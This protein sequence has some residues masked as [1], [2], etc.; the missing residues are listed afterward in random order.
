MTLSISQNQWVQTQLD[1]YP[2]LGAIPDELFFKIRAVADQ[3]NKLVF[4][5]KNF[6]QNSFTDDLCDLGALFPHVREFSMEGCSINKKP[7]EACSDCVKYFL[8]N[9][10]KW[11]LVPKPP[12][13]EHPHED[14]NNYSGPKYVTHKI[15]QLLAQFPLD[16]IPEH[17][18]SR[19][20]SLAHEVRVLDFS[21]RALSRK[22]LKKIALW[23]PHVDT[24]RLGGCTLG[25]FP[26]KNK[27]TLEKIFGHT[28]TCDFT[29][30]QAIDRLTEQLSQCTIKEQ[31]PQVTQKKQLA[32]HDTSP[33]TGF[34]GF[35]QNTICILLGYLAEPIC[36]DMTSG[37]LTGFCQD[38][39]H[40]LEAY[41]QELA[42]F[43][44]A[45]LK[46]A[47]ERLFPVNVIG[48]SPWQGL[49]DHEATPLDRL[50]TVISQVVDI[51]DLRRLKASST[52][53]D[54]LEHV[55]EAYPQTKMFFSPA[56]KISPEYVNLVK[57]FKKLT[58]L[59]I[60]LCEKD[61]ITALATLPKLISLTARR[62]FEYFSYL[63]APLEQQNTIV[64]TFNSALPGEFMRSKESPLRAV[65][66]R[67]IAQIKNLMQLDLGHVA[68]DVND[69]T[70][71]LLNSQNLPKLEDFALY[72]SRLVTA[73]TLTAFQG[74]KLSKLTLYNCP[75]IDDVAFDI[76]VKQF[77]NLTEL[78]IGSRKLTDAS[79]ALMP[80]IEK[81]KK[82]LIGDHEAITRRGWGHLQKCPSLSHLVITSDTNLSD[83]IF[84]SFA[85]IP[86]L[87]QL[88]FV[89]FYPSLE[90]YKIFL[91]AKPCD[92]C[93]V[94]LKTDKKPAPYAALPLIPSAPPENKITEDKK[95]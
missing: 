12:L 41:K 16:Q 23:F 60:S 14:R 40:F 85:K 54:W 34:Y 89:D 7:I 77:P 74:H 81:L 65:D 46:T 55:V 57:K 76:I 29:P 22:E 45:L 31:A 8:P 52:S 30:P 9:L 6:E 78:R 92:Q 70:L 72:E 63:F 10:K 26:L 71:S 2:T 3:V 15:N 13:L 79:F 91:K 11:S 47:C 88:T 17:L 86:K 18:L 58:F 25:T 93:T 37:D 20:R 95:A 84:L 1:T 75:K 56:V 68:K 64:T 28:L 66:I 80:R 49:S 67:G 24:L 94:I 48:K 62:F 90:M 53:L 51:V 42:P 69:A 83:L 39:E 73:T 4:R 44:S 35:S 5:N 19:V 59:D 43:D 33:I 87:R 27:E 21:G 50:T 36:L 38:I 61:T 82:V 32:S